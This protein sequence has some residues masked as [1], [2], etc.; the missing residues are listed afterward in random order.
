M[1]AV[2]G[3]DAGIEKA[4]LT[5]ASGIPPAGTATDQK[6]GSRVPFDYEELMASAYRELLSQLLGSRTVAY[7]PALATL[8]GGVKP[9]I[10]LS[11]LF[12][13]DERKGQAF[14]VST[15]VL[16]AETG[17]T[18]KEQRTARAILVKY[19]VLEL[20]RQS[21]PA[22]YFYKVNLDVLASLAGAT[23]KVPPTVTAP[24]I[25]ETSLQSSPTGHSGQAQQDTQEIPDGT[26]LS[27][28]VSTER[29]DGS[30]RP[31]N[32]RAHTPAPIR[33]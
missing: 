22:R 33:S 5:L 32:G 15:E 17:L 16:G 2:A 20:K 23:A 4:H 14:H 25:L 30:T 1:T 9:A 10:L 11:Q 29:E 27:T 3:L 26:Q 19:G 28:R 13:H 21:V 6:P 24:E 18:I 12:Y 8:V 31:K 7:K